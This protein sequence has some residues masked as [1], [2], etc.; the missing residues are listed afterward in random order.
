MKKKTHLGVWRF[1]IFSSI[2]L[3]FDG[4]LIYYYTSYFQKKKKAKRRRRKLLEMIRFKLC[5][6]VFPC[7]ASISRWEG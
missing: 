7:T 2:D 6:I 5:G 3:N 4:I 1:E